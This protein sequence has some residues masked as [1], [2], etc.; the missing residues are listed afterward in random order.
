MDDSGRSRD[1]QVRTAPPEAET[2]ATATEPQT[3]GR[4]QDL[5]HSAVDG[6]RAKDTEEC[7]VPGGAQ[8]QQE[9]GGESEEEVLFES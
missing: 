4:L 8:Q 9:I 6:R 7:K 5:Q 2:T 1:N 3:G